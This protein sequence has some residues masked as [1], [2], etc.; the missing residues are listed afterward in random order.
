MKKL[1]KTAFHDYRACSKS[2][3]LRHNRPDAIA[4]PAPSA[5]DQTRMRDGQQVE[6]LSH[7]FVASTFPTRQIASQVTFECETLLARADFIMDA[8][9]GRCDLIEVKGSTKVKE[10]SAL[11]HVTD[12]ALQ[13]LVAERSGR[14]V[15]R[16][17]LVHLNGD[18]CRRGD[19]DITGL[20]VAVDI[21]GEVRERLADLAG[22]IDAAAAFLMTAEIDENGCDCRFSGVAKRCAA[23][24]H[25]NPTV[26]ADGAHHL[27]RV[28]SAKLRKW[29]HDFSL[30]AIDPADLSPGQAL[31]HRACVEGA[32]ID[33]EA[34]KAFLASARYPLHFYDYETT[35]PAVPPVDGYRPYQAL[36]VQFSLHRLSEDG[37][38]EHFE[39]L[40]DAHGQ[41]L[42][43]IEALEGS[44]APTGSAIAWHKS[45]ENGC[46]KRLAELYPAKAEFLSSLC[47]RTVDLE[48]PFKKHYVDWGFRGSTSIKKVLPVLCPELSYADFEVHDGTGAVEAW[49]CMLETDDVGVKSDLRRQLSAYCELDSLAMV[50]IYE[51]LVRTASVQALAC[52]KPLR[53][54]AGRPDICIENS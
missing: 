18:Y 19:L 8:A 9:D 41:Q 5:M 21:T 13:L 25:F 1:T 32:V 20:F 40:A 29:E 34:I 38:L 23:F 37:N 51:C 28:S 6:A 45:F 39:W 2:F 54:A 12:A 36:P 11:D 3:W 27:P 52:L 47:E 49:N 43:L 50:R 44:F 14:A 42:E 16:V 30:H 15:D 35:G 24:H 10:S 17:Y 4:W 46:N 26:P 53:V 22:D 7:D 31:V 48:D 33:H